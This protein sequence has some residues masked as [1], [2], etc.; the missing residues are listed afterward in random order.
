MNLR[1]R[2]SKK[3]E[4]NIYVPVESFVE[5][6]ATGKHMRLQSLDVDSKIDLSQIKIHK[7]KENPITYQPDD[8]PNQLAKERLSLPLI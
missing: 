6:I 1:N 3:R 4:E 5:S 8:Q 7:M 2:L